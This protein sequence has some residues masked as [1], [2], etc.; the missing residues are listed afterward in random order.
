MTSGEV[1]QKKTRRR[2][3][4]QRCGLLV[5][6][7][8]VGLSFWCVWAPPSGRNRQC[9]RLPGRDGCLAGA[10]TKWGDQGRSASPRV[11]ESARYLGTSH[12]S[13]RCTCRDV[14]CPRYCM[15][16]LHGVAASTAPTDSGLRCG[17]CGGYH[18]GSDAHCRWHRRH[19]SPRRQWQY[20]RG[21]SRA[22]A[23][24]RLPNGNGCSQHSTEE[25]SEPAAALPLSPAGNVRPAKACIRQDKK[26][27]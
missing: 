10:S 26:A 11:R 20:R 6:S 21:A 18:N 2:G 17:C 9:C 3:L 16:P 1:V 27:N 25:S 14:P 7:H 13:Q 8:F 15:W 24:K 12:H 4:S 5:R 22:G 19:Q 23:P